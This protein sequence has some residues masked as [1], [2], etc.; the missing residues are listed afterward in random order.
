MPPVPSVL[1]MDA[2]QEPRFGLPYVAGCRECSRLSD[3]ETTARTERNPSREADYR[4][5][6]RR[7]LRTVH[8]VHTVV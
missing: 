7:H 3:G 8:H 4:V 5:L 6:G 2:A 1:Y